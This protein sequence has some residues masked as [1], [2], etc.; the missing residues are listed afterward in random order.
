MVQNDFGGVNRSKT[1]KKGS[2]LIVLH[3]EV[4]VRNKNVHK[5]IEKNLE[6]NPDCSF[7][8]QMVRKLP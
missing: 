6:K 5:K 3:T 8:A 4:E 7:L 1:F 2:Q